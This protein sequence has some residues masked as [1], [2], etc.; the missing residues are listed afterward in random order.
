MGKLKVAMLGALVVGIGVAAGSTVIDGPGSANTSRAEHSSDVVAERSSSVHERDVVADPVVAG[1]VEPDSPG[2]EF[3]ESPGAAAVR[4]LELTEDVV[5]MSPA[6]AAD[7]QRSISTAASAEALA[8]EVFETLTAIRTDVPEGVAVSIAPFG[9][10]TVERGEGWDVSIWYVEVVVYGDQLAVEQWRTSTYGV[11]WERG[12]WRMDSLSSSPG[13]TPV[14][15]ATVVASPVVD[16]AEAVAAS[17]D[18]V[19]VP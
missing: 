18:G 9:V 4:F 10:E 15:P 7:V 13:P 6:E 11:V 1:P 3:R 19:M 17:D 14:R 16:V 2:S 5:S 8:A 12:E